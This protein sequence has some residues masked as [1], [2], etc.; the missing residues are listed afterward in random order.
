MLDLTQAEEQALPGLTVAVLPRSGKVTLVN[1]ETR[2]GVGR[3]EEML[4]WGV[5][6]AQVVKGAMEEVCI[7]VPYILQRVALSCSLCMQAVNEWAASLAI[8]APTKGLSNL[9]PGGTG[10]NVKDGH[11]SE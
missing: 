1:L 2:V 8:A 4:R 5:E 6:G 3:F 10:K 7:R 11:M 9:L